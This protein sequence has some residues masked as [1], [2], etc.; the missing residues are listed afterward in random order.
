MIIQTTGTAQDTHTWDSHRRSNTNIHW[1]IY[2]LLHFYNITEQKQPSIFIILYIP[3]ESMH[4]KPTILLLFIFLSH[5][6]FVCA[7]RVSKRCRGSCE[8][9]FGKCTL[10]SRD[11]LETR[12]CYIRKNYC[13]NK[14]FKRQVKIL[15]ARLRVCH[16]R[17]R[18]LGL[19]KQWSDAWFICE[20]T[21]WNSWKTFTIV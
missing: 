1:G 13:T 15:R 16:Q 17:R 4:F 12:Y 19:T 5:V 3:V 10:M 9:E 8:E 11:A 14:C 2:Y 6:A 20:H 7:G 18:Q 21:W